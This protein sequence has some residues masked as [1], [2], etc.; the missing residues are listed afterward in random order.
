M[1]HL[2]AREIELV[3]ASWNHL[4]HMEPVVIGD[5]FYT[6]LFMEAP[7]L[8]FMFR[9][10][11]MQQA[12]KLIQT[13]AIIVHRLDRLDSIS[14]DIKSLSQRHVRYGVKPAHYEIV[15]TVLIWTLSKALGTSWNKELDQ[16]W[17]N[18]YT[19]LS[20]AMISA[21]EAADIAV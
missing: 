3:R 20:N 2:S 14:H 5:I 21:S 13:L 18:C 1:Q 6:K 17:K 10:P 19:I 12:E 4:R 16:A 9:S 15:G 7:Q 11:R 8:Q